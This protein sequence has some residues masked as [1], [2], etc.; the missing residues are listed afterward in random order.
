M[1]PNHIWMLRPSE[2]AFV[3]GFLAFAFLIG[4]II[5]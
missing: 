4:L 5:A 2:V 3:I 1:I